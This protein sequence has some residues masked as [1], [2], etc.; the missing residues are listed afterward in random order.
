M[1]STKHPA[2]PDNLANP[3]P[4][5]QRMSITPYTIPADVQARDSELF[6]LR[7]ALREIRDRETKRKDEMHG[8]SERAALYHRAAMGS[9]AALGMAQKK[10]DEFRNLALRLYARTVD[11]QE[12]IVKHHASMLR[13]EKSA[14]D[15]MTA[16]GI[17]A[18]DARTEID[19]AAKTHSQL[20]EIL[21]GSERTMREA[22]L[23]EEFNAFVEEA[24]ALE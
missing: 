13:I 19:L 7:K 15:L 1:Q 11:Q 4:K 2:S 5:R 14:N 24:M 20:D 23:Q 3:A 18:A 22:G 8:L 17:L 9:N 21:D 10:S 12:G 6:Q 16:A